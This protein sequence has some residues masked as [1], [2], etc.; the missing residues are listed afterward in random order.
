MI[1]IINW[2]SYQSYKDRKPPWIR[3]HRSLI[4][5]YEFQLMSSEARALLPMLWLL[6]CEH[7]DPT[8]G[9]IDSSIQKISFRLRLST[10]TV[11]NALQEIEEAKFIELNQQCIEPVTK[12]LQHCTKSVTPET[13]TETEKTLSEKKNSDSYTDSFQTFWDAY[14]KKTGKGKAFDIWKKVKADGKLSKILKA[15]SWQATSSQWVDGF[16]PLP[17]TYL[18][19]RRWDDEPDQSSTNDTKKSSGMTQAQIEKHNSLYGGIT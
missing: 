11:T 5:N 18:N 8:S 14:P 6:A 16:I 4:D 15:L 3:L 17:S 7:D 9:I 12:P 10:E 2:S 19:Q 1:K 13:E